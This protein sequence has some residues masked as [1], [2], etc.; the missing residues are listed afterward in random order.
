MS[1]APRR[2]HYD[3]LQVARKATPEE[4]RS[5][6]KKLSLLFHPDKNYDNQESAAEMF[7]DIQNAYAVLSDPDERSWY[8]A[9]RESLL[10]GCETCSSEYDINLYDYFTARCFEGFDDN[11]GGFYDVYGKVFARI[12]ET[13][14][15]HNAGAKL[16][17]SFGDSATCWED[18]SKFYTH[19]NN[20][21]S[22]KSFAWKDEYKV[23][24]IPDRASRRA[25]ERFN[26]KLRLAAKREYV[27]VVRHLSNFVYRRD[28]RVA[29]EAKL[30]EEEKHMKDK[31]REEKE[32][33]RARNRRLANKK[34]WAEAAKR[35][36]DE[37][38]ARA[39]RGESLDDCTLD[40]LYEMQQR[41]EQ[42]IK[43][44]DEN[45]REF[46]MLSGDYDDSQ[47]QK[48]SCPACK[49]QF[50][51]EA[52]YKEH[53]GSSKHKAKLRQLRAKNVDT[54]ALMKGD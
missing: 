22:Y 40:L 18:V 50:K 47:S 19:W 3:V 10:N 21:S 16:W 52:L 24:E 25:A 39:E 42:S 20:F 2:C 46:A 5:A 9:H 35:E 13:E 49:K 31:E 48:W 7:K 6:Y 34:L 44:K 43:M 4:I 30:K 54:E 27:Q 15:E 32:L 36:A 14:S 1:K 28:P 45:M 29:K 11:E 51:T 33:E 23:N 53:N 41:Q 38:A 26:Q 8:D 37:E 12:V 17:P